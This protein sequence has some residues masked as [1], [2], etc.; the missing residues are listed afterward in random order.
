[1]TDHLTTTDA[2]RASV[3][4]VVG[5]LEVVVWARTGCG[6]GGRLEVVVLDWKRWYLCCEVAGENQIKRIFFKNT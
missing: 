3:V 6:G 2:G 1:M 5:G 4:V